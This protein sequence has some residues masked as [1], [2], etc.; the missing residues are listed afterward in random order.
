MILGTADAAS[1]SAGQR[2]RGTVDAV[3]KHLPDDR[4]LFRYRP[5]ADGEVDGLPGPEGAFL[6]RPSPR[7]DEP[8]Q[9]TFCPSIVHSPMGAVPAG[10]RCLGD[11]VSRSVGS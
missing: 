1:Q 5:D 7:I 4:F 2:V 3:R 10:M 6:V 8:R 9:P 11:H